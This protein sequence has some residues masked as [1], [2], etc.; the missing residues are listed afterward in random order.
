VTAALVGIGFVAFVVVA[1]GA[2]T[3]SDALLI[4]AAALGVGL[5]ASFV[6]NLLVRASSGRTV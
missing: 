1:Q 4:L 6:R 3:G 5:M 2:E